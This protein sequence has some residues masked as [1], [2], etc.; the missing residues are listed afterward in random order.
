LTCAH[1]LTG[2]EIQVTFGD[3][4]WRGQYTAEV[5]FVNSRRDVAVLRASE[6]TNDTWANVRLSGRA[7][8]GEALVAIGNPGIAL[9]GTN[10]GGVS[11]GVVSNAALER[12]SSTFLSADV[13]IASGSSGGP[14]FS[15]KDGSLIGVVQ[16]AANTPGIKEGE[17]SSTGFLAL[18][19]PAF[20]L[21]EWLGL[22]RAG[23][24][25]R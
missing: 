1:V 12:K 10:F 11:A 24:T 18:A 13:S 14:L 4:P 23:R 15:L 2:P 7:K 6:M 20:L 25:P 19:A 9:G 5:I 22:T 3:G 16:F 21:P 17:V 8:P